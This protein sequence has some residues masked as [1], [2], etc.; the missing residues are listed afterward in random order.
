[1]LGPKRPPYSCGIRTSVSMLLDSYLTKKYQ[2]FFL[3]TTPSKYKVS[4]LYRCFWFAVSVF[5]LFLIIITKRPDIA[6]IHT[7]SYLGFFEKSIYAFIINLS[8]ISVILHIHGSEF[9]SFYS[10]SKSFKKRLIRTSLRLP[11]RIVCLSD[12]WRDFFTELTLRRKL[13]VI[14][15]A[16]PVL[17]R[18]DKK[19]SGFFQR[20]KIPQNKCIIL[21]FGH[22]TRRKGIFDIV[23]A[24]EAIKEDD[25]MIL[26]FIGDGEDKDSLINYVTR[27]RLNDLIVF[28]PEMDA[29]YKEEAYVNSDI[30]IL[31]SY[32]EGLPFALLEAMAAGL[33]VITTPVGGIP[34]VV[35]HRRNGLLV[36]SGDKQQ[37]IQSIHLLCSKKEIRRKLGNEARETIR[38]KYNL[39]RMI[40]SF[41][42]LYEEIL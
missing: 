24:I 7:S 38:K 19:S 16:V 30:F 36:K 6:H 33:P 37:L 21:F 40:K 8:G 12:S 34:E 22:L 3:K 32:D 35:H 15:N 4:V 1:M 27:K 42:R 29:M 20:Y 41:D 13:C 2:I 9:K 10:Q 5:R 11:V 18:R 26:L 39:K 28:I 23:D 14:P 25:E 31:P 17:D